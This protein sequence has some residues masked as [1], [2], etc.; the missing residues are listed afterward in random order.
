MNPD[1]FEHFDGAFVLG[2]LDEEDR[3]AFEAHLVTC[4][5]CRGRVDE[6]RPT[7]GVMAQAR[8]AEIP[9]PETLL[10][11]LLR[12]AARERSRR[13][14]L[15]GVLAAAVAACLAALV[16]VLWPATSS[17]PAPRALSPVRVS[18]ITATAVLVDREWGTE[19][20]LQCRY[21]TGVVPKIPYRLR[22]VDTANRTHDAGSWTLVPGATTDFTGGTEVRRDR[23]AKV[24]I[25]L[26]DGTPILQLA[27]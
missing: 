14:R 11:G 8:L 26:P 24:Q 21:E 20:D 4:A 19:I 10:P 23:I 3:W 7:V 6:L 5:D 18:A 2:A 17:G 16:V 25:T 12:K 1:P 27:L 22:V 9:A 15:T 13:R